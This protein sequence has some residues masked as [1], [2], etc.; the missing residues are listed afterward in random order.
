MEEIKDML[1][2]YSGFIEMGVYTRLP[3]TGP[4][5]RTTRRDDRSIVSSA[6][7]NRHLLL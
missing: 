6:L 7:R 2:T 4:Q 1:L 3:G 5:R